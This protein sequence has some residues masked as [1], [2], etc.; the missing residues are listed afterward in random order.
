[1]TADVITIPVA[2]S[3]D[4]IYDVVL[5][6][7]PPDH[8]VYSLLSFRPLRSEDACIV[9]GARLPPN[10]RRIKVTRISAQ[11]HEATDAIDLDTLSVEYLF[12]GW[13]FSRVDPLCMTF[14]PNAVPANFS[15]LIRAQPTTDE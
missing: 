5:E 9:D 10:D 13:S 4:H 11:S 2:V 7:V 14:R 3:V 8:R 1:M 6:I 12:S 15:V